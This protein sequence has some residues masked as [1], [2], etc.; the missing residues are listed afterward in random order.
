MPRTLTEFRFLAFACLIHTRIIDIIYIGS[1][2]IRNPGGQIA[3]KYGNIW[4]FD[5]SE[6]SRAGIHGYSEYLTHSIDVEYADKAANT[7]TG[8]RPVITAL[9]G[10]SQKW[11]R[12]LY[13]VQ[14]EHPH[15]LSTEH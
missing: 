1:Y 8:L 11:R 5:E 2:R 10:A 15:Q 6:G 13:N 7:E 9:V 3:R 12:M 4:V 14:S